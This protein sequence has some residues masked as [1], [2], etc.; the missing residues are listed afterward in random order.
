MPEIVTIDKNNKLPEAQ[1]FN[2]LKKE[3]ISYIED[4]AGKVWTDYNTHDP[5]ITLLE[6]MCYALT[7]LGYRTSFDIKDI[8]APA[9][10]TAGGKWNK[11]LY[12]A[13]EVLPCNPLTLIDYRKLI[14]DTEGVKNAW[15]EISDD[16]EI[17][18]YLQAAQ[19]NAPGELPYNLTYDFKKGDDVLRL[20]GLYKV[21]VEYEDDIMEDKKEDA[22]AKVIW[23]KL[24]FHRNLTEDFV[25]VSSVEYEDFPMQAI[26]QVSEGTDIEM[27]TARIF[28]VIFDFFSPPVNFYSLEQML[29]KNLSAEEI[30]E[31]PILNYGFIDAE[32]LEKSERSKNIHLSDIINII[33]S[34]EG[35]IAVKKIA[36]TTDAESPFSN[37]TEWINNVKDKQKTPRLDI[38]NSNISFERSGDRNRSDSK[39][40]VNKERVRAL[41][42]FLKSDNFK[43]RLRGSGKDLPVPEGEFMD[44]ADYYPFQKE[45]PAMYGMEETFI[46]EKDIVDKISIATS[47]NELLAEK[48]GING[49]SL[50]GQL[51]NEPGHAEYVENIID[52]IIEGST[53]NTTVVKTIIDKVWDDEKI[54]KSFK[55]SIGALLG[56]HKDY[57]THKNHLYNYV[58][59]QPKYIVPSDKSRTLYWLASK[60][61]KKGLVRIKSTD[62]VTKLDL[63]YKK[64]LVGK[65]GRTK[66]LVLQ[67]RGFL[68]AFEQIL[69]DYL[70]QLSRIR[71]IFSFSEK[72][73]QTFYPQLLHG[74]NDMET[75]FIDFK[76]YKDHQLGMIETPEKF[77]DKR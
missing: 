6:A 12:T 64:Y 46:N 58:E 43:T 7:D 11:I 42:S 21:F 54:D 8:I 56:H 5:G 30:F 75:L 55:A 33:S 60:E 53:S 52:E 1:N 77:S 47:V 13:R 25:S 63:L 26:I 15:I 31:G 51:R 44:I 61:L 22:V 73:T 74:I 14:I 17:L 69:A 57:I 32:E 48:T 24:Q 27:A 76:R 16:Y 29:E 3:G 23:Q 36:F 18:I 62:D 9:N 40:E 39:K 38:K 28:K 66:K 59:H 65:L 50:I 35:V 4:L 70:S 41:F 10:K 49:A 67:L 71:E 72:V 37:F 2:F 34:I 19:D 20:R 68:M 45:L